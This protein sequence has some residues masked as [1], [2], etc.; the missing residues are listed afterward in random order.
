[1]ST[2]TK[3]EIIQFVADMET[4]SP[5]DVAAEFPISVENASVRLKR[6]SDQGYLVREMIS[7]RRSEYTIKTINVET[8]ILAKA[9]MTKILK[10]MKKKNHPFLK[11]VPDRLGG[12]NSGGGYV[13]H[14]EKLLLV[15]AAMEKDENEH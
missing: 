8:D 7:Q 10:W 12:T 3:E 6:L 15:I 9:H 1:M 4:C 2:T 13:Y 11:F 5:A 14:W